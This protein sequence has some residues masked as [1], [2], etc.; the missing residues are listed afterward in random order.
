MPMISGGYNVLAHYPDGAE[1]LLTLRVEPV[2][3]Q[4]IPHGWVVAAV[5]PRD[6]DHGGVRLQWEI[7][8][9][10]PPLNAVA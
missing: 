4:V 8:V 9:E 6:D 7:T 5:T 10:R 2:Y 3:G 1:K